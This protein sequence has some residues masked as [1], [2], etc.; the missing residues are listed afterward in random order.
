MP[1]PLSRPSFAPAFA[2]A[3]RSNVY[4]RVAELVSRYPDLSRPQI[5]ELAEIFP[6]LRAMDVAL[7]MGDKKL[8]PRLDAFCAAN[9]DLVSPSLADYAVV[10]AI[11]SLPFLVLLV[12]MLAS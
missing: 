8:A 4:Q 5:D 1:Y 11:V 7:M 3:P 2:S 9:R 10:A 6:R 12:L